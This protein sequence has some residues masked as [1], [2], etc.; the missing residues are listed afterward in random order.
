[1]TSAPSLPTPAPPGGTPAPHAAAQPIAGPIQQQPGPGVLVCE[2]IASGADAGA[3]DLGAGC[4]RWLHLVVGG[5]PELGRTPSWSAVNR[6]L[7]EAKLPNARLTLEQAA[8]LRSRLGLTHVV[9]GEIRGDARHCTITYQLW[10]LPTRKIGSAVSVSGSDADV[11]AGLPR[12]ARALAAGL[13]IGHP[14]VPAAVGE[15]VDE[16]RIIGRLPWSPGVLPEDRKDALNQVGTAALSDAESAGRPIRPALAPFLMMLALGAEEKNNS[17][18]GWGPC[19]LRELPH[20]ALALAEYARLVHETL[21]SDLLR[22]GDIP[23]A[24]VR[25]LRN[26]FPKCYLVLA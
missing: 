6:A 8:A 1:A 4:G 17:V 16:L 7:R 18:T 2:P 3:A 26:H 22:P 9:L 14:R 12:I 25:L 19:A 10:E 5:H 20:N 23:T 15:T 11:T 13:G 21:Q 24:E